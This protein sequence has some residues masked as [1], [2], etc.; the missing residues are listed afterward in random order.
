MLKK[1]FI[2]EWRAFWKVPAVVCIFLVVYATLGSL[3]F[4]T[5]LWST[6]N[7]LVQTL[8]IFGSITYF[9]ALF[10]PAIVLV[11]YT[12]LRFYRNMYTD[13]GYLMHTLPV[14]KYE[15]ILSK[16]FV[17]CI[18]TFITTIA[19][20]LGITIMVTFLTTSIEFGVDITWHDVQE[21]FRMLAEEAFPNLRKLFGIPL[22]LVCLMFIGYFILSS[23]YSVMM[24]YGSVSIGHLWK[25]HPVAGSIL[26][27]LGFYMVMNFIATILSINKMTD[28]MLRGTFVVEYAAPLDT[29]RDVRSY[30]YTTLGHGTILSVIGIILFFAITS[31]V[32]NRKLNLD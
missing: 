19:M 5:P 2:H 17:A 4:H 7:R 25:K 3:T 18:W 15:L 1:L 10:A 16:A 9:V 14:K 29:I 32:M 20:F 27:Y 30:I 22:W 13:E 11:L 8:L 26:S 6:D 24:I 12:A 21:L 31:G 23:I 28:L